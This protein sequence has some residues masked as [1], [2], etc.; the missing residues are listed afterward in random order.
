MRFYDWIESCCNLLGW[1]TEQGV[2]LTPEVDPCWYW[3]YDDGMSPEM[4][5]AEAIRAGAIEAPA[6]N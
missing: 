5:V 1:S 4:A 2:Q 3:C 6:V